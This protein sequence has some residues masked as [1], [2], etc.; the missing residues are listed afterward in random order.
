MPVNQVCRRFFRTCVKCQGEGAPTDWSPRAPPGGRSASP[1]PAPRS[2][3]RASRTGRPSPPAG[4]NRQVLGPGRHSAPAGFSGE[5]RPSAAG[6]TC[7]AADARPG[8]TVRK[9]PGT[10]RAAH[11]SGRLGLDARGGPCADVMG[12]YRGCVRRFS[13]GDPA[14]SPSEPP[15]CCARCPSPRRE[16]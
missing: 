12:S 14:G 8:R 1:S 3:T 16:E 7:G 2:A 11:W 15:R 5:R 6:R 9:P 10:C 4:S 13:R